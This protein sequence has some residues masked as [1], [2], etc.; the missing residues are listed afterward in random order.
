MQFAFQQ[1]GLIPPAPLQR[2]G[3]EARGRATKAYYARPCRAK[4]TRLSS[5]TAAGRTR[6]SPLLIRTLKSRHPRLLQNHPN[7]PRT[8]PAAA[9]KIRSLEIFSTASAACTCF[10]HVS[11]TGGNM[12]TTPPSLTESASRLR[13]AR[14]RNP[15]TSSPGK[16]HIVG[17][18]RKRSHQ[19]EAFVAK[20]RQTP[21]PTDFLD[22]RPRPLHV[23]ASPGKKGSLCKQTSRYS[24]VQT[25]SAIARHDA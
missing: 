7:S 14:Q 5:L 6:T 22:A 17:V 11:A 24:S 25:G 23:R 16:A 8:S 3:A 1:I 10:H 15:M 19:A 2:E 12:L 20:S 9:P 18:E 13:C 21:L 4:R